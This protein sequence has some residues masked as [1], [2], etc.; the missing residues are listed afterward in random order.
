MST[1]EVYDAMIE[2]IPDDVFVDDIMIG[3]EH[4]FVRSGKGAGISPYRAYWQRAPQSTED[5]EGKPLNEVAKLVKSW[6]FIEASAGG[7]AITAWYNSPENAEKNGVEILP[8]KRVEG[9]LK[10]P[11]INSQNDVKGKKVCVVGHFPFLEGL[12][13]PICDLSIVEWDP[14][15]GDYPYT[16]CEYLLPGCD[17]AFL[18]CASINDKSF[19]H[20]LELSENAQKV[21]VVGPGTPLAPQLFDYGVNDLSGF[22][23]TDIPKARKIMTGAQ[24]QRIYSTGAKVNFIS[25]KI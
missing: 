12:F 25:P 21:T 6:N 24:F 17:F 22:V 14:G 5:K 20:L 9:R 7:A 16:A 8:Q 13:E 1:W 23:I 11:F 3:T 19:P 10:D 2:G 15:V 18:T 4:A